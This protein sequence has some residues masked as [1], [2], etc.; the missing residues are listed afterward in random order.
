MF[1]PISALSYY[2]FLLALLVFR[3]TDEEK[4][5]REEFGGQWEAYVQR[6]WRPTFFKATR[7]E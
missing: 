5:L 1:E 2:P 6:S 3:L 4:L 7:F